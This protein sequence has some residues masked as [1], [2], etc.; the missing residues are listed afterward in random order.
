[1]TLENIFSEK[2]LLEYSN[3]CLELA[4]VVPE[5]RKNEGFDTLVIPSRGAVPFFLGMCY[6][7]NKIKSFGGDHELFYNDLGVQNIIASLL[8]EQSCI[9]EDIENSKVKV[10][11]VP[12]TAD[13]NISKFEDTEGNEEYTFET[14]KYWANV[15]SSFFKEQRERK[16]DPY[17]I[18]FTNII[19][20]DIEGREEVAKRYEDFPQIKK[21]SIIDT[22]ISGRASNQIL[23]SFD[24]LSQK[25]GNENLKPSSFLIIDEEG[26]KLK[27]HFKSYL[28]R[29]KL[30]GKVVMQYVPRIVSEDEGASFLG[31]SAIVYPSLMKSSK[32]FEINGEEFFMG[33][34]SW[35]LGSD[36]G[37]NYSDNF[38]KFME[39]IYR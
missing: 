1:M 15:T 39:I 21:F 34:G 11:V 7:L 3:A 9:S 37:K 8:P 5:T 16:K 26:T 18:S 38:K 23:Q 27:P 4:V 17:F 30:E 13:L 25:E 24:S 32:N 29:K 19:L 10:I 28:L 31:V 12:F 33:A 35:H 6:S 20:R 14:R 2:N 22:V 36:L